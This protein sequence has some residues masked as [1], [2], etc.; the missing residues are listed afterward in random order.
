MKCN[1][2]REK[3]ADLFD[4]TIDMQT[5]TQLDEHMKSCP[6][7]KAYYD[8]LRETFNMLQPISS[9]KIKG[10]KE[11]KTIADSSSQNAGAGGTLF[12][13][14]SSF[15]KVA[16]IFIAA[17]LCGLAYA[18]YHAVSSRQKTE[19]TDEYASEKML[20]AYFVPKDCKN[21]IVKR[22][23]DAITVK[24]LKG[25]WV[26]YDDDAFIEEHPTGGY[27][28]H[29]MF[30]TIKLD[31]KEL[32]IHN[33]PDHPASA[34]KKVE[35]LSDSEWHWQVNLITT[36]VQVPADVKGNINP[37]LTILLT[38][39]PPAGNPMKTSIYVKN[40]TDDSFDWKNHYQGTSWKW[41]VEDIS[42]YL[43][44][45]SYRKDHHVRVNVCKSTPQKHID[46]I[47]SI[48]QE[49]NVTNCEIVKQ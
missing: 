33:L 8:E 10:E 27:M 30:Y 26:Q 49:C 5:Q 12:I 1:E 3:V 15:M 29:L 9:E 4:K 41:D 40:G 38:G 37:E 35:I 17:F 22:R 31:G 39:T 45:V 2:F 25:T 24:W 13:L 19:T 21:P 6:E 44:E 47:K 46:R 11:K 32:D 48:M 36:P 16:A 42:S 34:L 7:C 28:L 14:R 23:G 20:G 43:K 18:A